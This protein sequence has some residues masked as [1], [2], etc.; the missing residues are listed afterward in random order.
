M[1]YK[2][3]NRCLYVINIFSK[4]ST[5][6]KLPPFTCEERIRAQ[7][8]LQ[9]PGS[10]YSWYVKPAAAFLFRNLGFIQKFYIL[11]FMFYGTFSRKLDTLMFYGHV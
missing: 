4:Q 3:I 8:Y 9:S 2:R 6:K 11:F 5:R 7:I 10:F 1:L